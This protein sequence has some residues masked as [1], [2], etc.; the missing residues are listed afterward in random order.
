MC[1]RGG[2]LLALKYTIKYETDAYSWILIEYKIRYIH[3]AINVGVFVAAYDRL[4]RLLC[5][6]SSLRSTPGF[7]NQPQNRTSKIGGPSSNEDEGR[8][9]APKFQ[10]RRYICVGH[11]Q[12]MVRSPDHEE[13]LQ[14]SFGSTDSTGYRRKRTF[15]GWPSAFVPI[16]TSA[17][18]PAK[19]YPPFTN[20]NRIRLSAFVS[21]WC[22]H[23]Q[24]IHQ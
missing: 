17:C 13:Q 12:S 21:G 8:R 11:L 9:L 5:L 22:L 20:R 18:S 19:S 1:A 14:M 24:R 7:G 10:M 16:P 4:R 15:A 3:D 6:S 23:H 2:L